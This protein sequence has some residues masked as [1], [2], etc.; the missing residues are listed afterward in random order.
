M[1]DRPLIRSIIGR[2]LRLLLGGS[3]AHAQDAFPGLKIRQSPEGQAVFYRGRRVSRL[4]PAEALRTVSGGAAFVVG[5]GPSVAAADFSRLPP[6]SAILL[7]GA[8][9][10]VAEQIGRP[11]AV[12]IEDERFVWRHFA[13]MRAKIAPGQLCLFSVAVLRAICEHDPIWLSDKR[14]VLIDNIAKPYGL[15]RRKHAQ[16]AALDFL[17]FDATGAFGFSLDPDRGVFQGGSV[18]VSALQFAVAARP[19]RIG[20]IG[21]DIRNA[22]E[23][24][25]Y[26][27]AG[28]T[29]FSGIARAEARILGN[30][31]LG[32]AI[33]LE[34]GM[35]VVNHA[36]AS[37]LADAG[38]P[39][40]DWLVR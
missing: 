39:F 17:R 3:R 20:F 5:S 30:L 15:P 6:G 13:L 32:R 23:P 21:V 28:K 26:E 25:F 27:T 1:A 16:L 18:A 10:L 11:L 4:E 37:A 35:E 8:I 33:A 7:N 29:A 24:R 31:A 34:Q 38:F 12:A 22:S 19:K 2:G 40:D 14:T 36:P 9:H